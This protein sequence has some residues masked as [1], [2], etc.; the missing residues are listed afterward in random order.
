MP[1]SPSQLGTC[2]LCG[3][4]ISSDAI[5]LKYEVNGEERLYAECD[6]CNEPV[7]PQ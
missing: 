6:E 7:H 3:S 1:P 5:I 2:P 4:S